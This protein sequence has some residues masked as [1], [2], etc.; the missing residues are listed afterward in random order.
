MPLLYLGISTSLEVSI[1]VV[2]WLTKRGKSNFHGSINTH[3]FY[4]VINPPLPWSL[5]ISMILN[6]N[7]TTKKNNSLSRDFNYLETTTSYK[8]LIPG[9]NQTIA[10]SLSFLFFY[11]DLKIFGIEHFYSEIVS[12]SGCDNS[13]RSSI[14]YT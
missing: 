4:K 3:V 1:D 9:C 2:V 12:T 6:F 14:V 11:G 13:N 5:E 7:L 8:N 10:E